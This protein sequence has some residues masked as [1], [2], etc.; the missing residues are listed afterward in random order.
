M[1]V[2]DGGVRS[3]IVQTR[4][5]GKPVRKT[6]GRVDVL[7]W[8]GTKDAPGALDL[9]KLAISAARGGTDIGTTLGKSAARTFTL[10]QAWDAYHAAGFP[11]QDS[12]ENGGQAEGARFDQNRGQSVALPSHQTGQQA[13]GIGHRCGGCALVRCHREVQRRRWRNQALRLLLALVKFARTRGLCETPVITVKAGQGKS[14]AKLS[15]AR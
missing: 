7:A 12:A 2:T 6:L 15:H 5:G 10:Q 14:G 13:D 3:Y 4:V 11:M 8:E 9:A 1:R